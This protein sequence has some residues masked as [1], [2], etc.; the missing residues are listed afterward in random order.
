M[1]FSQDVMKWSA[2]MEIKSFHALPEDAVAIRTTVFVEEQ[3]FQ[4]EFDSIDHEAIHFVAYE[5]GSPIA[6]C[7]IFADT[8]DAET[9]I[10]GRFAVLSPCRGR[11]VGREMMQ[12]VE[13]YAAQLGISR[14]RLHAQ[15]RVEKFYQR[16]RF[17]TYGEIELEENC[18]HVWMEKSL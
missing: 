14:L 16:L 13:Q 17:S 10:L 18:P 5:D 1:I 8:E 11:G 9:Y 3:G 15:C 7:R 6:T 2:Y 4:E 12:A